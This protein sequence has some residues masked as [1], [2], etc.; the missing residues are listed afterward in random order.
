MEN[1]AKTITNTTTQAYYTQ[2]KEQQDHKG[3]PTNHPI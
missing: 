1:Q 2:T 3:G